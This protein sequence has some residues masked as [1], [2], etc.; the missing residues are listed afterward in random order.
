MDISYGA[1]VFLAFIS[2]AIFYGGEQPLS[3]FEHG[4]AL[5]ESGKKLNAGG[6]EKRRRARREE[7][8]EAGQVFPPP[9][10]SRFREM[11]ASLTE[12]G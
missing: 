9:L 6:R 3:V 8:R 12:G 10:V 7:K 2:D 1:N 11:P 4:R 5:V